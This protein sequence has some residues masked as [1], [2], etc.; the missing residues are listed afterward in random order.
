[1]ADVVSATA[2]VKDGG[3]QSSSVPDP[4]PVWAAHS[5]LLARAFVDSTATIRADMPISAETAAAGV[6]GTESEVVRSMRQRRRG[7]ASES[8][9]RAKRDRQQ[10]AWMLV[11][12]Q[13]MMPSGSARPLPSG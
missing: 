5:G 8:N 4:E 3:R 1:M 9:W 12:S 13:T 10:Q 7:T 2:A 11:R 6:S